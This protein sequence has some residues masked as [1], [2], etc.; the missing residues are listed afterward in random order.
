MER[1]DRN[2]AILAYYYIVTPAFR[3]AFRGYAGSE[4]THRKTWN[5]GSGGTHRPWILKPFHCRRI[6]CKRPKRQANGKG[7]AHCH[8]D[9]PMDAHQ[10][11]QSAHIVGTGF[12]S[13]RPTLSHLAKRKAQLPVRHRLVSIARYN[14]PHPIRPSHSKP[15]YPPQQCALRP[16]FCAYHTQQ[17]EP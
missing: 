12:R 2:W 15:Y 6:G 11:G 17:A 7:I 14:A 3:T 8:K 9:R 10:R 4:C 13:E 5:K 16:S 1:M